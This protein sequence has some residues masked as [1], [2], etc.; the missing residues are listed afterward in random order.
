MR[1]GMQSAWLGARWAS[2]KC[3]TASFYYLAPRPCTTHQIS[4]SFNFKRY[5]YENTH[6]GQKI[7]VSYNGMVW[8][9]KTGGLVGP[10]EQYPGN[11]LRP[12]FR[13]Q[14]SSGL[15]LLLG[16]HESQDCSGLFAAGRAIEDHA[17]KVW[18]FL[19]KMGLQCMSV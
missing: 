8:T 13:T 1:C 3:Y 14:N 16:E 4:I 18:F 9:G 12:E 2:N 7:T 10:A 5:R 19:C 17:P 6:N 15:P 11:T